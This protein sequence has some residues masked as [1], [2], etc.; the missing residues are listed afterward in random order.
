MGI[1][2]VQEPALDVRAHERQEGGDEF[3]KQ[4]GSKK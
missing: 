4:E 3:R 1:Q 2:G